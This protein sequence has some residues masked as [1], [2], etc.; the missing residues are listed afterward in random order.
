M[1]PKNVNDPLRPVHTESVGFN[2]DVNP[3]QFASEAGSA[4][5]EEGAVHGDMWKRLSSQ[6]WAHFGDTIRWTEI[7]LEA[8]GFRF[9]TTEDIGGD[10]DEGFFSVDVG[11]AWH[12]FDAITETGYVDS[13]RVEGLRAFVHE[14]LIIQ[15]HMGVDDRCPL[16]G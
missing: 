1:K 11:G 10:F 4:S 3:K 8:F 5:A 16:E 2:D 15:S 14:L 6:R 13:E 9:I 12:P 7:M